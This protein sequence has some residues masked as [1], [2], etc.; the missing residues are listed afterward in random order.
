MVADDAYYDFLER[1]AAAVP[2]AYELPLRVGPLMRHDDYGALGL[3]WKSAP[4]VR[5]SL[6]RVE[7]Y[8]RLWTDNMTYE[9]RES[10]EQEGVFDFVLHRFGERRLGM[11]LSNESTLASGVSLIRQAS[12]PSFSP[13]AVHLVHKAPRETAA[14]T[15]Y[16]GCA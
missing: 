3:A 13:A 9:L 7:R 16:F 15:R 4:T 1:I 2:K 8:C 14:H 11:R 6:E 12:H 10:E 5:Q